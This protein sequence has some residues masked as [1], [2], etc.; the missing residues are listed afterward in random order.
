MVA[1]DEL[2][3]TQKSRQISKN[4]GQKGEIHGNDP[5][6][7]GQPHSRSM[8]ISIQPTHHEILPDQHMS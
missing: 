1:L 5:V 4:H 8:W 3:G 6:L 2:R 7:Q